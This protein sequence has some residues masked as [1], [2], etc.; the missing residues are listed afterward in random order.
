MDRN[1]N[2]TAPFLDTGQYTA[3]S[4][5][6]Y[7]LVYGKAFVSPGGRACADDLIQKMALAADDLV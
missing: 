3:D 1:G 6:D 2:A 4:I 5:Q 7:E